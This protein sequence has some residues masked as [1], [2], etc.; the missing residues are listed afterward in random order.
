[1][2][3]GLIAL[4]ATA[5]AGCTTDDT[6]R[7]DGLTYGA[8]DAIAANTVMQMVDPWQD[9]VQHTNL[10]VPAARPAPAAVTDAKAASE[11]SSTTS[12]N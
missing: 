4:F 3:L 11:S 1:M 8:G 2:R 10:K 9:G 7:L 12:E 5:L 6:Q